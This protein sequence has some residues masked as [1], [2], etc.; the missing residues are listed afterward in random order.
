MV[1][2]S[3]SGKVLTERIFLNPIPALFDKYQHVNRCISQAL[4]S[5]SNEIY[6]SVDLPSNFI[7]VSDKKFN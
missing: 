2:P 5:L 7:R 6:F 1:L 3:I 4:Y